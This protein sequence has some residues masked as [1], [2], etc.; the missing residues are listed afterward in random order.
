MP[1]GPIR[2]KGRQRESSALGSQLLLRL[3]LSA[4]KKEK[5]LF[6]FGPGTWHELGRMAA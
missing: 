2:S 5:G 4:L 6:I 1:T 3:S